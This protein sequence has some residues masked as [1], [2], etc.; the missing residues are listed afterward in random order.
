MPVVLVI[1]DDQFIREVLRELLEDA[2]Y[3]VLEAENGRDGVDV[4]NDHAGKIAAVIVDL[5][6]PEM[7]GQA[8]YQAI[9]EICPDIPVLLTS[10]H[11]ENIAELI[12][13]RDPACTEFILKPFDPEKLLAR[14]KEFC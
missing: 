2:D 6:M 5:R 7:C 4:F 10:G 3:S 14:I 1:D 12:A 9:I 11:C 13:L 8:T